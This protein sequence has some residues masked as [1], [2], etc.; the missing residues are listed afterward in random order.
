MK[1]NDELNIKLSDERDENASLKKK[2]AA[3]IKDLTRQLQTLQKKNA[4]T[5]TA[6]NL[7][8]SASIPST[9]GLQNLP[10][11]E[12]SKMPARMSRESSISSL[13]DNHKL[14]DAL[15]ALDNDDS[16]SFS[17]DSNHSSSTRQLGLKFEHEVLCDASNGPTVGTDVYVVDIDK[18][19]LIDKIVKLQKKLAKTNEKIDFLQ[20]HINQLTND[21]KRKTRFV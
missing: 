9:P 14:G 6:A 3:N 12:T 21:L 2:H 5:T 15:V 19:K 18:Q 8:T 13:T 16:H 20:D 10:N 17:L 1:L 4:V 11:E 7:S